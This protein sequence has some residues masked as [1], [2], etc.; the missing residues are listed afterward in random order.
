M[1]DQLKSMLDCDVTVYVG[2][3][4]FKG[5][6]GE[7]EEE[8]IVLLHTESGVTEIRIEHISAFTFHPYK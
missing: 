4:I 5:S 6:I 3:H 8:D 7:A 2:P 1:N